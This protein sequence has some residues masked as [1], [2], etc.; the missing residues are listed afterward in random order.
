MTPIP[1]HHFHHLKR[2]A[3]LRRCSVSN[4]LD[5]MMRHVEP[6]DD[7]W[8][9]Q[10]WGATDKT[11]SIDLL[12]H[13]LR[14]VLRKIQGLARNIRPVTDG[15]YL[16]DF[17][18]FVDTPGLMGIEAE[19]VRM[20]DFEMVTA[21][22]REVF[23]LISDLLP[24]MSLEQF[25]VYNT[26][27]S[28]Y[29]RL[30][31]EPKL[32]TMPRSKGPAIDAGCYVG[33]KA[34]ALA[35]FTGGEPVLAFELAADNLDVLKRNAALNP[36][37]RIEPNRAALSDRRMEMTINTR[38]PRTMAHSLTSFDKLKEANQSLLAGGH[39]NSETE[40]IQT[41]LLD[42]YTAQFDRLSAVH[43]SVNGH[44]P[45]VVLGG[46]ETIKKADILRVSCPYA[47]DGRPVRDLVVEGFE[48]NGVKVFGTSGAAVI[49]GKS[50]GNYHAVPLDSASN[51]S[52][53][54]ASAVRRGVRRV[55]LSLPWR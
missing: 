22:E 31:R 52:N 3:E 24:P 40:T 46:V 8:I 15:P 55:R 39:T 25:R 50:L 20:L 48:K 54:V 1:L 32:F 10:R 33:Y 53:K 6:K 5:Y 17:R 19:G 9:D 44:E 11:R 27:N 23:P 26:F 51:G 12:G 42:E 35:Q 34:L 45:E 43:I 29:L 7:N 36:K 2:L 38:N 30:V 18:F 4:A 47:R 28:Q 37:F 41:T 13:D 14:L 16:K 49:A 21:R